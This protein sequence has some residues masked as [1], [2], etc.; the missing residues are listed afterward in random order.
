MLPIIIISSQWCGGKRICLPMQEMQVQ[1]QGWE[2]SLVE[3]LATHSFLPVKFHKQRSLVGH[4]PW[5]HKVRH[6]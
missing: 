2:D 3:E 6:Y 5:S 4:S 1:S